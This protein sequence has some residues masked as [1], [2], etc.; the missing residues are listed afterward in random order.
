MEYP[1]LNNRN[2]TRINTDAADFHGF[3]QILT[4]VGPPKAHFLY[5]NSIV[6]LIDYS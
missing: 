3:N 2:G 5:E 6:V 1:M 4:K